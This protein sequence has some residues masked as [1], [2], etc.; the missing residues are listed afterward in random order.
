MACASTA[1]KVRRC[2]CE[3]ERCVMEIDRPSR[4]EALKIIVRVLIGALVCSDVRF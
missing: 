2:V 3:G 4:C 1:C